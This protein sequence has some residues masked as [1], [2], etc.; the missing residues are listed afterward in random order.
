MFFFGQYEHTI[1]AK[2]RLAIP[3]DLRDVLDEST[4]GTAF[5]AGPGLNGQ[6]WLWP[7]RTFAA[8]AES[9]PTDPLGD[10]DLLA[11][12]QWLF[13]QSQRCPIDSA[14]RVRIPERLLERYE[15]SRNVMVLGVKEHLEVIDVVRWNASQASTPADDDVLRRARQALMS[16]R[17]G[18]TGS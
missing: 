18:E 12:E 3:A 8:Y 9:L 4:H 11:Y 5:I 17:R 16:M 1:D 7:E 13:S 15:L 14:G 10:E 6:L 2:Q